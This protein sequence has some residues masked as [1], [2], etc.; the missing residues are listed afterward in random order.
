MSEDKNQ[1]KTV[2]LKDIDIPDHF[3]I[4]YLTMSDGAQLR[5]IYYHPENPDGYL[6][7]YP[8]LN[9]LVLSWIDIIK[10]M[11]EANYHIDYVESREKHTSILVKKKHKINRDRMMDDFVESIDQLDIKNK[12]YIALGSSLGANTVL[13]AISQKRV[14]PAYSILVGPTPVFSYPFALDLVFPFINDW[15]YH[16]I[17]VKIIKKIILSRYTDEEADPKQHRKYKL[18]LELAHIYKLKASLRAWRGMKLADYVPNINGEDSKCYFIGAS[19]DKLHP[20]TE[21]Q[22][23]A[24]MIKNAEFIDLKTNTAAHDQPLIDLMV[25]LGK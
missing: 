23:I 1:S 8:G 22:D 5:H 17:G 4:D 25:A 21:T 9:T 10:G 20:E 18:S 19:Q 14:K 24:N 15:I 11:A 16:N 6:L 12:D 3:E 7:L 13:I 2:K